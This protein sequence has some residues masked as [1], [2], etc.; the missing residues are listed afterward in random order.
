MSETPR[1]VRQVW[2]AK[3]AGGGY[4]NVVHES[5]ACELERELVAVTRERDEARAQ[6]WE[7]RQLQENAIDALYRHGFVRCDIAAC[8]CGSWHHRYGLPERM[9]E[10]VQTL[11]D[12]GHSLDNSNGNL[13]RNALAQLVAERDAL[14]AEVELAIP[15]MREYAAKNPLHDTPWKWQDPNGVHAWLSRNDKAALTSAEVKHDD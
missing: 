14:R 4:Y 8:N 9:Q 12:A 5:F 6:R 15:A 10:I 2:G 7:A 11:E 3:G 1:T 13:P